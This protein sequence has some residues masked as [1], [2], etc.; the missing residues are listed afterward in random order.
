MWSEATTVNVSISRDG[1]SSALI[2][3]A[4]SVKNGADPNGHPIK[5]L[6]EK[7]I[8]NEGSL[9]QWRVG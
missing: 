6:E 3:A 1:L 8:Q 5:R 2:P 7:V 4:V 9:T